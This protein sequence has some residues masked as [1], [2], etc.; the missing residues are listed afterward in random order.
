MQDDTFEHSMSHTQ[1][2]PSVTACMVP[3]DRRLNFLPMYFG[4]RWMIDGEALVYRWLNR[5]C[6]DYHSALW[7]FY[8]LSNGGFYMAPDLPGRLYIRV[9]SNGFESAMSADA[10][11]I[12]A[13]LFALAEI[14]EKIRDMEETNEGDVFADRYHLL[15][16][17]ALKHAEHAL[18]FQAID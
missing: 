5:L 10:A 6:A 13:T 11:G 18:I 14:A 4:P 9:G 7:H 12:V 8:E 17:F 1:E 3:E 2:E 15:R 16:A